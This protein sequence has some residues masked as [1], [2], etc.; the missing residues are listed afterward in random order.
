[1]CGKDGH[2]WS[3]CPTY[4]GDNICHQCRPDTPKAKKST[5]DKPS[6]E[7]A[8][9]VK[10]SGNKSTKDA[11]EQNVSKE[12][13]AAVQ[14]KSS[15][16]GGIC[17]LCGKTGH[18]K[19]VCPYAPWFE[20][21]KCIVCKAIRSHKLWCYILKGDYCQKCGEKHEEECEYADAVFV[22][23]H[24]KS[25]EH[26]SA[27]CPPLKATIAAG[28]YDVKSVEAAAKAREEKRRK[29]QEK[30]KQEQEERQRKKKQRAEQHVARM[31][32]VSACLV[33][34][35][36]GHFARVGLTP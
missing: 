22:C 8:S 13:A 25:T 2:A 28:L 6:D 34:E 31:R 4:F 29:E 23:Y 30:Q 5:Q 18:L 24:C 36:I 20:Q 19:M 3:K 14:G 11:A 16:F 26:S 33:C 12:G 1:M 32:R 35:E 7:I 9:S 15:K 27:K 17:F 21:G 10:E